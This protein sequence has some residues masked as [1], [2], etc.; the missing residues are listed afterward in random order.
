[1]TNLI[2]N[3]KKNLKNKSIKKLM[4]N[5]IATLIPI[6]LLTE[7]INA[8]VI[9]KAYK[10]KP[11]K[12]EYYLTL[13]IPENLYLYYK[14]QERSYD[15]G[16]YVND[17]SDDEI[18][19][20]I[21]SH[22]IS[23]GRKEKMNFWEIVNLVVSFVQSLPY[24]YDSE[25]GY[26][27]YPKYPIETLVDGCG[28]CEDTS[29]LMASLLIPLGISPVLFDLPNHIAVG[30]PVTEKFINNAPYKI[31]IKPYQNKRYTYIETTGFG[32]K[33]GEIPD[34]YKSQSINIIPLYKTLRVSTKF[35]KFD[36]GFAIFSMKVSNP[37]SR[38]ISNIKI[39]GSI[40]E[41]NTGKVISH[42][43]AGKITLKGKRYKKFNIKLRY[44]NKPGK[45]IARVFL[46][47]KG[48]VI[49]EYREV[50]T[51]SKN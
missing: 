26:N 9:I 51:V 25:I 7:I 27:E 17:P 36:K 42:I 20:Y 1:M 24:Q 44:F 47:H 5:L 48:I 38:R 2:K 14:R 29:I 30:I 39:E 6:F 18:I 12:K 16:Q 28:D 33:I 35:V 13:K 49:G 31:F 46:V 10:W 43:L 11:G 41:K 37:T 3:G 34:K 40:I 23:T 21:T 45:Y 19:K 4:K 50:F 32:W 22:F 15:Y 8:K